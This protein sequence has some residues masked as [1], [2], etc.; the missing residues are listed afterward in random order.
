MPSSVI[1]NLLNKKRKDI[2]QIK[3]TL[4]KKKDQR[5]IIVVSDDE[6]EVSVARGGSCVQKLLQAQQSDGENLTEESI[7]AAVKIET[8]V[9]MK[10]TCR[11]QQQQQK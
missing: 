6:E 1:A 10:I 9:V 2:S 3:E 8:E 5:E 4:G 11:N 7:T